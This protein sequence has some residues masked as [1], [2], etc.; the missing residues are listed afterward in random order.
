MIAV[1]QNLIFKLYCKAFELL[2]K[3]KSRRSSDE[4]L[5]LFLRPIMVND[6]SDKSRVTLDSLVVI[7]PFRDKWKLTRACIDTLQVQL[8]L[9]DIDIT[10]VLVDN[11]SCE[12]DTHK[13]I[14]TLLNNSDSKITFIAK[15]YTGEFNYSKLCN[16]GV[17][18]APKSDAI[19]IL[20]N[21]VELEGEMSLSQLIS[22]FKSS[23]RCGVMGC[24]L[25]YPDRRIQHLFAAPGLKI[26]AAHPHKG[27]NLD[28]SHPW[29]SSPQI[30]PAIT[31]ALMLINREAFEAAGGF[32]EKLPS[33]G[34][35]IDFCLKLQKLNWTVA[36]EPRVV[37]IHHESASRK[38]RPIAKSEVSYIYKKW[39]PDLTHHSLVPGLISRWSEQLCETRSNP[40][41]LYPWNKLLN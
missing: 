17:S 22:A 36:V 10:V 14:K 33:V 6:I 24:T 39:G 16:L 26:V 1:N 2:T 5:K 20:N 31:G 3:V 4:L 34:Q 19:L 35:D 13:G 15:R 30:V 11:G 9:E 32:D 28:T 27:R 7:I 40:E 8:K 25:L 23:P 18:V 12:V 38:G 37:A 29:Y 41:R 21:D